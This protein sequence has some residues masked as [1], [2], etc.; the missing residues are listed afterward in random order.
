[1]MAGQ[2]AHQKASGV[3]RA[4]LPNGKMGTR[5]IIIAWPT[6]FILVPITIMMSGAI[7]SGFGKPHITHHFSVL[8]RLLAR[9]PSPAERRLRCIRTAKL[10]AVA[11]TGTSVNSQCNSASYRS[12]MEHGGKT[13]ASIVRVA[14]A[15]LNSWTQRPTGIAASAW[16]HDFRGGG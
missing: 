11:R 5:V 2:R 13:L 12:R 15:I 10:F 1:M 6:I 14:Y 8:K 7:C 3:R 16:N 4:F 9:R